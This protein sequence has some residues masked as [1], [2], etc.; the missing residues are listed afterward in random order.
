M[1]DYVRV[2]SYGIDAMKKVPVNA[3]NPVDVAMAA[4]IILDET[5][6]NPSMLAQRKQ[7]YERHQLQVRNR[8]YDDGWVGLVASLLPH[9]ERLRQWRAAGYGQW[10]VIPAYRSNNGTSDRICFRLDKIGYR[11]TTVPASMLS[12]IDSRNGFS[13]EQVEE[14]I[15]SG[16][17]QTELGGGSAANPGGK[18]GVR[19]CTN[20]WCKEMITGR[21]LAR[22]VK[23]CEERHAAGRVFAAPKYSVSKNSASKLAAREHADFSKVSCLCLQLPPRSSGKTA[24]TADSEL[25]RLL[26]AGRGPPDGNRGRGSVPVRGKSGTGTGESPRFRTNRGRGGGSVPAPGQIGDGLGRPVPVPRQIGD[27]DRTGTG[28]SAP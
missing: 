16:A 17:V 23:K 5:T 3:A 20:W 11:C 8:S 6:G 19:E 18:R 4:A 12:P 15:T 9:C 28:V 26:A 7:Y 13:A 1:W 25:L 14:W 2:N 24:A 10:Y 27:R 22:H 21:N